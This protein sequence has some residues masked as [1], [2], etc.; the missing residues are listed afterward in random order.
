MANERM[1]I[2]YLPQFM[3]DYFEMQKIMESEQSQV[4]AIWA[5]VESS[6]ADQFISD[7]TE[8]G[9]KRWESMLQINPKDTDSL[10]ERKFRILTRLNQELPYTMRGLERALTNLC[11]ADGYSIKLAAEEYHIEIKLALNYKNNYEDV[12]KLLQKMIPANMTQNVQI[13]YNTHNV[14]KKFTHAQLAAYSHHDLRN[15]VLT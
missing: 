8:H 2:N 14:L 3:Q 4:D 1:L 13:I 5:A 11:G 9:V 7:A 6:F 10:D 12:T 15:E